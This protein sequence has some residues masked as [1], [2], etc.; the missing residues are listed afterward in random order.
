MGCFGIVSPLLLAI[1][2]AGFFRAEEGYGVNDTQALESLRAVNSANA[3]Y[4]ETC[5]R[6]FAAKLSE[7]GPPGPGKP[8]DCHAAALIDTALASGNK[9]GYRFTYIVKHMDSAGRINSYALRA[10][11]TIRGITGERS[12]YADESG[13]IRSSA[14]GVATAE[15]G[16]IE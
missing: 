5:Q 11:P 15:S 16:P 2:S 13:V 6:G 8:A 12:F 1:I 4:S 10:D 14:K 9:L 3:R 7:L